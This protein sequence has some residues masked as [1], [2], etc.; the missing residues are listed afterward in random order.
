MDLMK[1]SDTQEGLFYK[2]GSWVPVSDIERDDL[3]ELIKLTANHDYVGLVE[4]NEDA[5]IKDLIAKTIYEQVYKVLK[6]L[7]ENRT[8]YLAAIEEEFADLERKYGLT[9]LVPTQQAGNRAARVL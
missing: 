9:Q 3:L 4:C 6:D 7:D 8:T 5:P 1:I 2:K